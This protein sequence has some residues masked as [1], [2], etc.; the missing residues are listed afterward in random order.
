MSMVNVI[1][2]RQMREAGKELILIEALPIHIRSS[3]DRRNLVQFV[4]SEKFTLND[5]LLDFAAMYLYHFQGVRLFDISEAQ[6]NA[7][8][9]QKKI[10][11]EKELLRSEIRYLV[12]NYHIDEIKLAID[13]IKILLDIIRVLKSTHAQNEQMAKIEE[14]LENYLTENANK[15]PGFLIVDLIG[16]I[17]GWAKKYRSQLYQKASSLKETS[18]SLK[19]EMLRRHEEDVIE[20]YTFIEVFNRLKFEES[21][22]QDP[23]TW[24]KFTNVKD[25]I[26]KSIVEH[27]E[28]SQYS[29]DVLEGMYSIKLGIIS[30]VAEYIDKEINFDNID[31]LFSRVSR[32]NLLHV[33]ETLHDKTIDAIAALFDISK[34][35]VMMDLR[36]SGISTAS[37]LF[38]TLK[39]SGS[40]QGEVSIELDFVDDLDVLQRDLR[41]L[42]KI[43]QSLEKKVK[44]R[45]LARGLRGDALMQIHIDFLLK[46]RE[47]LFGIEN[48]V[49]SELSKIVTIPPPDKLKDMLEIEKKVTES[50]NKLGFSSISELQSAM[51]SSKVGNKIVLDI[52]YM[53]IS[54]FLRHLSR[55]IEVYL[56]A[57]KD[58]ER[59]KSVIKWIFED[60]ISELQPAREEVLTD[61]LNN[62]T[63]EFK[64]VLPYLSALDIASFIW[65]RFSSQSIKS[66]KED[67]MTT[68]SPVFSGVIDLPLA[69]DKLDY[70]NYAIGY[71]ISHRYIL[72]EFKR[73]TIREDLWLARAE[74]EKR[75][76]EEKRKRVDILSWIDSRAISVFRA[77]RRGVAGL[78]W[79]QRDTQKASNLL[80]YF[81]INRRGIKMCK[82]C[83]KTI[84]GDYCPIHGPA[85]VVVAND[86]ENLV[87]FMSR[88]LTSIRTHLSQKEQSVSMSEARTI[89]DREL[90]R[91]RQSGRL[92][93]KT[94]IEELLPGEIEQIVGPAMAS[95][96]GKY[97][98]ESLNYIRRH[99]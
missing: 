99:K 13:E 46:P 91:L 12:N 16:Y 18:L 86:Y 68:P 10:E 23:L 35:E 24:D 42:A 78:E 34:S 30:K 52:S 89:V 70:H 96:I 28:R 17:T 43:R 26:L 22:L 56:K 87:Y 27:L 39:S 44:P 80:A 85:S 19:Q 90:S 88:A 9:Q 95:L 20:I 83:G 63:Y 58:L 38:E 54:D 93:S 94:N 57:R 97:F 66:A 47:K 62:T 4:G 67:L 75:R 55:V 69:I 33:F 29:L 41:H 81:L 49:L 32:E 11:E 77:G 5:A 40:A 37:Q 92:S 79:T 61:A 8:E 14:I 21:M 51:T 36:R 3:R 2:T 48:Q 15:Y 6:L 84:T 73:K 50:L 7:E 1:R 64:V 60:T 65:A 45:L 82:E 25:D 98:N 76:L 71:D 72:Q 53:A 74:E 31:S 59:V